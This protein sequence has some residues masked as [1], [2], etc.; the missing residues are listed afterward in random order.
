[1]SAVLNIVCWKGERFWLG[2]LVNHPEIMSQGE[3]LEELEENLRDAYREMLLD[4]VP[5]DYQVLDIAL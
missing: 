2:K 4:D 3:T 5:P 1:M